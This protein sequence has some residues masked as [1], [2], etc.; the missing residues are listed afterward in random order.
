MQAS[1]ALNSGA[2]FPVSWGGG[3]Q[4]NGYYQVPKDV[5]FFIFSFCLAELPMLASLSKQWK[6]VTREYGE[7]I[8]RPIAFGKKQYEEYIG[9]VPEEPPIPLA[10]VEYVVKDPTG[11][12]LTLIP[13]TINGHPVTMNYIEILVAH[14]LKG[15]PTG[16]YFLYDPIRKEYGNIPNET[17]HWVLSK[18]KLVGCGQNEETQ[19]DLAKEE[20]LA[21]PELL[22]TIVSVFMQSISKETFVFS[23]STYT[24][25]KQMIE[26]S[27]ISVGNYSASGLFVGKLHYC[28]TDIGVAGARKSNDLSHKA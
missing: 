10:A 14:P 24:L 12:L 20:K 26:G 5:I 2:L 11:Y 19:E 28:N 7:K 1:Q 3:V 6:G 16:F 27:L 13:K 22:D 8:L 4:H 23:N 17:S 25:L 9:T 18:I 21:W 15:N